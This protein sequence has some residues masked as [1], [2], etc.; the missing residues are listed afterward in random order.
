MATTAE[1]A[2]LAGILDGEGSIVMGF[3]KKRRL[4]NPMVHICNTDAGIVAECQR[5]LADLKCVVSI[6]LHPRSSSF[7]KRPLTRMQVSSHASVARVLEALL[8]YLRSIKRARA[9]GMLEFVRSRLPK[10]DSG[11][12]ESRGYTAREKEVALEVRSIL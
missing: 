6:K 7:G 5:I 3:E 9:E 4:F 1:L 12:N 10:I 2:W 8:P 11:P